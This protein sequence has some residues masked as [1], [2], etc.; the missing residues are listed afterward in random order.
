MWMRYSPVTD[1]GKI[2]GQ[3]SPLAMVGW[4][5]REREKQTVFYNCNY[6]YRLLYMN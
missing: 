1:E 5:Q 4:I 2:C 3:T 6:K